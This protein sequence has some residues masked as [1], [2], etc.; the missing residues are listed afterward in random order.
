LEEFENE[1]KQAYIDNKSTRA[2]KQIMNK[3]T[4]MKLRVKEKQQQLKIRNMLTKQTQHIK[5]IASMIL[6]EMVESGDIDM[7]S[8]INHRI[9]R[10]SK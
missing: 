8:K 5:A 9:V 10:Y 7:V 6:Q 4:A 3:K 1:L 2:K